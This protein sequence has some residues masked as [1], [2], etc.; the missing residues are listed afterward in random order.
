MIV[1]NTWKAKMKPNSSAS[2]SGP[3]MNS[4]PALV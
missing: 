4:A 2:A 3:K 1:G